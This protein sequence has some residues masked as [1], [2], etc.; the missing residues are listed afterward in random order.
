V[1]ARIK[2]PNVEISATI[3]VAY[4]RLHLGHPDEALALLEETM[5]RLQK[6]AFG[7]HRWRWT[8]HVA[9]HLAEALLASGEPERALI[10]AENALVQA[11]STGSIKYV[12]KA[13]LLRGEV[14]LAGRRWAD[15][16]TDLREALAIGQRIGYPTLVWQAAHRL[17][18]A[19]ARTG[20]HAEAS[21]AARLV[22][23]TTDSVAARAPQGD[24][25][26]SFLA[27]RRVVEARDDV[28]RLLRG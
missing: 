17:A 4:D 16:A 7:A 20:R 15:A 2:N 1:G 19:E 24:L 25:R 12:G 6:F 26:D 14:A 21:T 28:E 27:W 9:A 22:V 8:I 13:H 23:E 11:R 3:N 5:T 18:V 10:Q